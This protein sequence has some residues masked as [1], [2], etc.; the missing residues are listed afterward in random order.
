MHC[1][2][3]EFQIGKQSHGSL[4]QVFPDIDI[5]KKSNCYRH[6]NDW[7]TPYS[8]I[9]ITK[10]PKI[11]LRHPSIKPKLFLFSLFL[12]IYPLSIL[13]YLSFLLVYIPV[14]TVNRSFLLFSP[15]KLLKVFLNVLHA[16]LSLF[17]V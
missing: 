8:S 15:I 5:P 17:N 4:A 10:Q 14:N 2:Y 13:L 11:P 7:A 6:S 12:T 16:Y 1:L 3:I 9:Q